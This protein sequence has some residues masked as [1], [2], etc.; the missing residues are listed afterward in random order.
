M[1]TVSKIFRGA[2]HRG[3]WVA[4]GVV[5][6]VAIIQIATGHFFP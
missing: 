1:K 6:T 4:V 2:L 5:G 3:F